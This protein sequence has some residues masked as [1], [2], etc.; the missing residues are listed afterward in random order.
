MKPITFA[1]SM[2]LIFFSGI[3]M[4][5]SQEFKWQAEHLKKGVKCSDCHGEDNNAAIKNDTC[6]HCHGS[7][8]ELAKQTK[9]MHLN[10][11]FSPHFSNL[12][13]TSCHSTHTNLTVFCQDCH[14]PISRDPKFS[15]IK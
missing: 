13:C 15:K 6:T 4:S 8:D 7:Y 1:L 14:G 10:P 11:H 5:H 12:E 2:S 9:D 3:G